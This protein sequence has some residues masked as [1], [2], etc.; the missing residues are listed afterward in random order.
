MDTQNQLQSVPEIWGGIECTINRVGDTFSDQLSYTQCYSSDR[1]IE[2]F[3][4]LGIKALRFPVL[5]E[6]HQPEQNIVI[7]WS[8]AE[9]QLNK[10]RALGIEPIAGLV[11]HGSGPAYTSLSDPLFPELL[12]AYARSVAEKFPWITY[13][14]PVNEPLTTA[15]FSGLYGLW[16]PHQTDNTSF[17][18]MLVNQL[19]GIVL[20]MEQIR[21]VN[22]RAKLVQTEDLAKIHSTP[23]LRY[24]RNF[25]NR[26]RWLSFD[27]LCGKL[28]ER[29]PLWAFCLEAGIKK[30][31][32]LFFVNNPCPPDIMGLNYYVTSERYLDENLSAYPA[33]SHGGNGKVVY[34]DVEAVRAGKTAGLCKLLGEAWKRYS[35]PIAVTEVHM[36]C[37]R[38]EQLRWFKEIW[39]Q[40]L[41]AGKKGVP[42]KAVTAWSLLGAYDWNS[43]L[44]R[45]ENN[46]EPGLFDTRNG[47]LRKTALVKLVSSLA[48]SCGYDHPLLKEQGWW[49][50]DNRLYQ[51]SIIKTAGTQ[52]N[53]AAV[54]PLL[55]IG[56][57]GTLGNAFAHICKLRNIPFVLVGREGLDITSDSSVEKA[58]DQYKPWAI[59]NAAGY[60]KVDEAETNAA[61]CFQL[62]AHGPALLAR[63]CSRHSIRLVTFSSDLVFNGDK[64]NPYTEIDHACPINVYGQSKAYGEQL[65]SAADPSALI[66]R[67]SSFFGPWD[68][69]NFAYHVLHTLK[70]NQPF[71]AC[72]MV[73]SPT[74]VPDLVHT[75]LDLLIDE[76]SGTWHLCNEGLISWADFAI[77]LAIRAGYRKE[78][79]TKKNLGEMQ[80]RAPR[81]SYSAMQTDKGVRLPSLDRAIDNYF[82][83]RVI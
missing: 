45:K 65:V 68:T 8:W 52:K 29:H 63:Y 71:N 36:G 12:A 82:R 4:G 59:I 23:S 26:R 72:D 22:P 18:R 80:W 83:D 62:N 30:E 81:P 46:Y 61:A 70:N 48:K 20:S 75:T 28:T 57:T 37:S 74:Y 76:E 31:E 50:R 58:I 33:C 6:K 7:D 38:E 24:Q 79:I 55:I 77:E 25:E 2:E 14:T 64:K 1:Y 32:L 44:T 41:L 40:C 13:Y 42:V 34:A 3:A 15:R 73:M 10:I 66:I 27:L 49:K 47:N 56:K 67:T 9:Q 43:L 5:W 19:K 69:Y 78:S 51:T 17:M 60:V 53:S 54:S 11:H 21:K 39:Q 16:Y 35:L